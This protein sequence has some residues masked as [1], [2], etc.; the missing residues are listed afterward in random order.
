[1]DRKNKTIEQLSGKLK[2]RYL[3]LDKDAARLSLINKINASK[4][5]RDAVHLLQIAVADLET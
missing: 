5:V 3:E 1:M 2:K 4:A